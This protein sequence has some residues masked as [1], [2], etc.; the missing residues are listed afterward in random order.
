PGS[1]NVSLKITGQDGCERD[2]SK[3]IRVTANPVASLQ[4]FDTCF[5]NLPRIALSAS[6]ADVSYQWTLNGN[7]I[8]GDRTPVLPSLP[9]GDYRLQVKVTSNFGCGTPAISAADFEV[10]PLPQIEAV[11]NDGCVNEVLPFEGQQTDAQTTVSQWTWEIG[12][13]PLIGKN[14]DYTF[15]KPDEYQVVLKATASNG[16]AAEPV[17]KKISIA[18][19]FIQATDTTI[20]RNRPT[21]LHVTANG[22]VV[23]SPAVGLSDATVAAPLATLTNEQPYTIT[24][25][26]PEGC[27]ADATMLVKVFNGPTVYVP[28]AFTPNGDGRNDWLLPVYVGIKELKQFAVYNRWGQRVF[29]TRNMDLGWNG[30]GAAGTYVW[31]LE[32]VDEQGKALMLKGSVVLIR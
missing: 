20:I 22:S 24:V 30:K 29:H 16:C 2:S 5:G 18:E 7:T 8:A 4:V 9:A 31:V 6:T 19:A 28:S 27:T 12:N 10:K 14:V 11:V 15:S 3:T 23:W 21:Q 26:T 32:A 1:Y 17:T 25:T 13:S